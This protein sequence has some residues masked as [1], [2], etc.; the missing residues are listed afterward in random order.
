MVSATRR[1]SV[2]FQRPLRSVTDAV[3][4]RVTLLDAQPDIATSAARNR[5]PSSAR[6]F[7]IATILFLLQP[8]KGS[9]G[10][11]SDKVTRSLVEVFHLAHGFFER[12]EIHFRQ[13][14]CNFAA[15]LVPLP[16]VHDLDPGQM[17]GYERFHG[18]FNI[19]F[20]AGFCEIASRR[21]RRV[22]PH[23]IG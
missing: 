6:S 1:E 15:L 2:S 5:L 22:V 11:L 18:A 17:R 9:F 3:S 21:G 7:R 10:I 14:I 4:T 12:S 19:L 13:G 23:Q 20:F 16:S 8:V